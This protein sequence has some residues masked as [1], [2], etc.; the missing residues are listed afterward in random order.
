MDLNIIYCENRI[1]DYMD[2]TPVDIVGKRCYHFIHAED[3]EGI[4]QCHLD[5]INKG[6]CVTKYYRWIQKNGGYIW[7]QSSATISI[8]TKN[9][10]E[11][12][13]IW[14]NYVLSNPEYK[15]VPMDIAQL[16]NLPEKAS[17]S[18]ETSDSES[19]F[20]DN[21]EDNENSKSDGKGN[22]SSENSE[23]PEPES[24][25]Q[26]RQPSQEMRRQEEGDS[27]SNPE[28]QDSEDS[29]EPSDCEADSKEGR[30]GRL[31]GL[32]IKVEHYGDPEAL[33]LHDS[34]SSSSEEEEDEED[35]DD[36][37]EEEDDDEDPHTG[38]SPKDC[39]M[40]VTE[41]AGSAASK[42]QKR[43]K[44]EKAEVERRR[45]EA[46]AEADVRRAGEPRGHGVRRAGRAAAS[47]APAVA[48]QR[49]GAQDQDG[50]V[51]AHQL[52]QRQ[53]HLELPAQP[54]D[55]AQRVAL[56]HDQASRPWRQRH[57]ALPLP[58]GLHGAPGDHPR[59][60]TDPAGDGWQRWRSET[61]LRW[62]R[63]QRRHP[64]LHLQ[65]R[66]QL[67]TAV[68]LLFLRP[69]LPTAVGV[70][71][72]QAAGRHSH[73]L[74]LILLWRRQRLPALQRRPRGPTA[75]AGGQHGPAAGAPRHGHPGRR[76]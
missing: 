73:H 14:V 60:G 68:Q 42:H 2:L 62:Q 13:I 51:G 1:S 4:R 11:K 53:Q 20:K 6:Q 37:E 12:N 43:K 47:A 35:D 76:H 40:G 32:H 28:S 49:L 5:L 64:Q 29:L 41:L 18:S 55:L 67:G 65:R 10:N 7:I 75:T 70:S 56:Q 63:R 25:K 8:N 23:D 17:E 31:G 50:D 15:D 58:A 3:V 34:N 45:P 69:P 33:E 21:S 22:Q 74:L 39:G 52:R 16:P 54:G 46:A 24:K 44:A 30:L 19:D 36:D 26:P 48:H 9:A 71:A 61:G 57:R 66:L 38:L 27:S 59:L 72:G